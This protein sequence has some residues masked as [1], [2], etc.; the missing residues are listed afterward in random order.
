MDWPRMKQDLLANP[1][2]IYDDLFP[3]GLTYKHK[4][5]SIEPS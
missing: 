2:I 3:M 5:D 4:C 1:T